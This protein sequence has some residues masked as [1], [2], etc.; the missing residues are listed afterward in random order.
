MPF[1]RP[2]SPFSLETCATPPHSFDTD[3]L[4]GSDDELDD[5]ASAAQRQRI[6]K[7]A[8]SYLQGKPLFILSAGLKGPL[9]EEWKNP[10]EKRRKRGKA[11][12]GLQPEKANAPERM[13]KETDLRAPRFRE[14]LPASGREHEIPASSLNRAGSSSAQPGARSLSSKSPRR[15]STQSASRSGRGDSNGKSRSPVKSSGLPDSS[16]QSQSSVRPRPA[17]W[18]KKDRRLMNFTKFDPPSS[19]TISV[20]SRQSDK[21]RRPPARSVQVQ[22]P[23]TP[24]S[25][26]KLQP[27]KNIPPKTAKSSSNG[28]TPKST[29][30]TSSTSPRISKSRS[31]LDDESILQEETI[32]HDGT[33]AG[34]EVDVASQPA[35]AV[36][37]QSVNT[38]TTNDPKE[39]LTDRPSTHAA[40]VQLSKSD[41]P[42]VPDQ[43]AVSQQVPPKEA[44]SHKT[45]SKDLR[46]ADQSDIVD[47]EDKETFQGTAP[48]TEPE[49]VATEQNTYEDLPSA[50][51][52]PAP[53]GASDRIT[54]LHS[55]ALPKAD[56]D[57]GSSTSPD[58][59]LSTQAALLHAQKSFQEDL[60]SPAY[61]AATPGQNKAIH[62]PSGTSYSANVTP[63][64]RI[65]QSLQRDFEQSS[66]SADKDRMQA[67]STQYMLDAATPFNFSIEQAGQN[68]SWNPTN[69]NKSQAMDTQFML[70][71]ATPY[72]FSTEKKP[73]ASL[74]DLAKS[75]PTGS[76]RKKPHDASCFMSPPE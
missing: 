62:S 32:L 64:Y 72:A 28:R 7:L 37:I 57:L 41:S 54:S 67:M 56:T 43:E 76:K 48:S 51:R 71:A 26:S 12:S 53:L 44:E 59:Q 36:N 21:A 70:D 18:L 4:L 58:T 9:D 23:Q 5:A 75:L 22:V 40:S 69:K 47:G 42:D 20:A 65:E 29:R 45:Q 55:T 16:V 66:L 35:S 6:E 46:F 52:V 10:W 1:P 49:P 50:Q 15:D 30:S 24:G 60:D 11:T 68:S 39:P 61:Y 73:R 19:P 74:P 17:D 8:E 2:V 25:P 38:T 31:S 14:S 27:V 34:K 63:F 13:V 3:A 33:P